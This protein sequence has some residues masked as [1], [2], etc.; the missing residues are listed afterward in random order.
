[1]FAQSRWMRAL[2]L[3]AV[4]ALFLATAVPGSAEDRGP[5]GG[6]VFYV[7]TNGNDAWSGK[8]PA[9]NDAKTDGPFATITKARDAVRQLKAAAPVFLPHRPA[10][11]P[12]DGAERPNPA[13]RFLLCERSAGPSTQPMSSAAFARHEPLRPVFFSMNR[14]SASRITAD[15][16]VPL[17]SAT[18]AN[19][20]SSAVGTFK[21]IVV[22]SRSSKVI[23][24][25][26]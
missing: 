17:R 7:A 4:A 12:A 25:C 18:C 1:M 10:S 15:L 6:A 14:S 22:M 5:A 24:I 23:P 2:D 19:L 13:R 8:L 11:R 26:L 3:V 21:E 9:P 16:L 20:R